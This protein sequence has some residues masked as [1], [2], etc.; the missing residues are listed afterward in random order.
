DIEV[1]VVD[2]E[3]SVYD[4]HSIN[5]ATREGNQARA[6]ITFNKAVVPTRDH[7]YINLVDGT[8]KVGT[9]VETTVEVV[10]QNGNTVLETREVSLPLPPRNSMLMPSGTNVVFVN[11]D[12]VS[13][14]TTEGQESFTLQAAAK[15]FKSDL[16]SDSIV[17]R[18]D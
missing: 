5:A 8:A 10:F 15:A 17:I 3:L 9:D 14:G 7:L 4:V 2:E 11:M 16:Q 18:A 6:V 12:I 13:D 1:T